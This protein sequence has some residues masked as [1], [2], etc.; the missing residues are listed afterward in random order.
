M[1]SVL[2]SSELD[3]EETKKATFVPQ[4]K[5]VKLTVISDGSFIALSP[6]PDRRRSSERSR[7][8]STR[9]RIGGAAQE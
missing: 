5:N 7:T 1:Y 9:Q 4:T 2:L 8:Q 6:G 3:W